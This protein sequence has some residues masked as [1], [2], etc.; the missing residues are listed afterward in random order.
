MKIVC[1]GNRVPAQ[2]QCKQKPMFFITVFFVYFNYIDLPCSHIG[3]RTMCEV[4]RQVTFSVMWLL[5]LCRDILFFYY[6]RCA[7]SAYHNMVLTLKI[8]NTRI[9]ITFFPLSY[10]ISVRF[11]KTKISTAVRVWYYMCSPFVKYHC[12]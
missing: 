5:V 10:H 9:K 12:S 7:G 6:V 4:A 2:F 1:R 3:Q 8:K 11:N